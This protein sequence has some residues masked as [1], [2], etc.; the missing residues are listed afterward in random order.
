MM[1]IRCFLAV[2]LFYSMANAEVFHSEL[3]EKL[4]RTRPT[5]P[6]V[7]KSVCDDLP[8]YKDLSAKDYS[9]PVVATGPPPPSDYTGATFGGRH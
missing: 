3:Y 1:G 7:D 6:Q 5:R 2:L 9:S 4:Q 8:I